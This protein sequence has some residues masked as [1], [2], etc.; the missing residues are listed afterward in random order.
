MSHLMTW[1]FR[2]GASLALAYR[3]FILWMA[4]G[5]IAVAA[6]ALTIHAGLAL[7]RGGDRPLEQWPLLRRILR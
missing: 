4:A 7:A 2:I 6:L 1:L 3:L 5:L